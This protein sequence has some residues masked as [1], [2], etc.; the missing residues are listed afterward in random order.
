VNQCIAALEKGYQ[1]LVVNYRGGSNLPFTNHI[2]YC[3]ASIGDIKEPLEHIRRKYCSNQSRKIFLLG[4]SLGANII[5]N[6]LGAEGSNSFVTAAVS[7]QPPMKFWET[8]K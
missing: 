5:T 2:A 8:G 7:F 4:I 1:P 6:Y 3:G